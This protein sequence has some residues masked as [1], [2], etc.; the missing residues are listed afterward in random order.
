[1][2]PEKGYLLPAIIDPA[3]VG[4]CVP[5]PDDPN[6]R[7]AFLGALYQL[8]WARNWQFGPNLE[9]E[10]TSLVWKEIYYDVAA[11]IGVEVCEAVEIQCTQYLNTAPF[12][13][14][15]PNDPRYTP[16]DVP[17]GYILPP[18]Y[19]STLASE[20]AYETRPGDIVT[21]LERFP[22]GS[23]PGILPASGLPRCRVNVNVIDGATVRVHLRNMVAG[24]MM[25]TTTDD[26]ILTLIF[27]DVTKDGISIPQETGDLIILEFEFAIGGQHHIDLIVVPKVND[28]I[29]FIFYGGGIVKVEICGEAVEDDVECC[30]PVLILIQQQTEVNIRIVN[31]NRISI[32]DDD[33]LTI[34]INAPTI[35]FA[36]GDDD[37]RTAL[38]MA[39][40]EYVY[41]QSYRRMAIECG[42]AGIAAALAAVGGFLIG[43]PLGAVLGGV[44]VGLAV[45]DCAGWQTAL[46]DAES[47]EDTVCAI[48]SQFNGLPVSAANFAAVMAAPAGPNQV[49]VDNLIE[50]ADEL[51]NYLWFL[52]MLGDAFVQAQ[53]GATDDCICLEDCT[54]TFDFRVST[55][56]AQI[57]LGYRVAGQGIEAEDTGPGNEYNIRIWLSEK[58][59][60]K[61][62]IDYYRSE[63]GGNAIY[64][65]IEEWDDDVLTNS[66]GSAH[67]APSAGENTTTFAE[68][69]PGWNYNAINIYC[70]DYDVQSILREVRLLPRT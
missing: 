11:K 50:G 25:Q 49:V 20:I 34:N 41:S 18:W 63:A 46:M 44:V 21:T 58:C 3:R 28:E 4:V 61:I 43:G 67:S 9:A 68:T 40:R 37:R 15:F 53:A 56:G 8:A 6:H 57:N 48:F 10:E 52:D 35:V 19:F 26:D 51:A 2:T 70:G 69:D 60:T 33:P 59:D 32:W 55:Y 54:F 62:E 65:F 7:R 27:W 14:Y 1:M 47:L 29:P 36:D 45:T 66:S 64:C 30:G 16:N 13:D 12:I 22:P 17:E 39:I 38:C 23:L 24:S 42:M 31:D 5:V